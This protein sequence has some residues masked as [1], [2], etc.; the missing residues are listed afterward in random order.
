[1]TVAQPILAPGQGQPASAP[2]RLTQTD[3]TYELRA[4]NGGATH[5]VLATSA[6]TSQWEEPVAIAWSGTGPDHL[7]VSGYAAPASPP[8]H[9]DT[10]RTFDEYGQVTSTVTQTA[11]GLK[12]EIQTPR[13]NDAVNWHLALVES[14]TVTTLESAKGAVP[15]TQ[16]TAYTYTS[17]GEIDTIAVEPNSA[18]PTLSSKTAFAVDD[19][20]LVRCAPS[21]AVR[22]SGA[23]CIR[24]T[25]CRSRRWTCVGWRR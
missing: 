8:I 22:R 11:K 12:T 4:F 7:H 25:A 18:D 14:E 20:G 9:V 19:Y 21:T 13:I 24:R 5:A 10:Q 23:L 1:V 16:T 6:H 17:Q 3:A 2:A 15:V